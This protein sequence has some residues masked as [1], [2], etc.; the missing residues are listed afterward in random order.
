[1]TPLIEL[2]GLYSKAIDAF[3]N[4]RVVSLQ[5]ELATRQELVQQQSMV[6]Q[7]HQVFATVEEAGDR[8]AHLAGLGA[9]PLYPAP[10]AHSVSSHASC[11]REPSPLT[12]CGYA[13]M[14]GRLGSGTGA[15]AG[16]LGQQL[17]LVSLLGDAER[18]LGDAKSSLSD[19]KSSLGDA[20]S[21]L[22]DAE[23]S[24]GDA[25]SSLGDTKSSLGDAK[26]SLSDVKS[27]LGD[28]KS[29]LGDGES[30]LGD[31]K[32]SL[33]DAT[34]CRCRR[35]P[36]R[37][38]GLRPPATTRCAPRMGTHPRGGLNSS[39][40]TRVQR[41]SADTSLCVGAEEH[42]AC[43][44]ALKAKKRVF[45]DV[46]AG[47]GGVH[48]RVGPQAEPRA[49]AARVERRR[50]RDARRRH[51]RLLG[52]VSRPVRTPPLTRGSAGLLGSFLWYRPGK[53]QC[54]F[55]IG[56]NL[57]RPQSPHFLRP[58]QFSLPSRQHNC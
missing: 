44:T 25:K 38:R 20:K 39:R 7:L 2:L 48:A 57:H 43:V 27:S 51:T 32:S 5:E 8:D 40:Y 4:P 14:A 53:D 24:L 6:R 49:L 9:S 33:G 18:S 19:V 37:T 46:G 34:A 15:M 41:S 13:A 16:A 50:R 11:V 35:S 17:A 56:D 31:A 23:S 12:R 1:L 58:K 54:R 28:A 22:G 10:A 47:A 36:R 21:S 29:S 45:S 3:R 55:R 30:S 52:G 42:H 26:S